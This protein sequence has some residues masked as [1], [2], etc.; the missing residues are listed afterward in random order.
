MVPSNI[1]ST[2][3]AYTA[4]ESTDRPLQRPLLMATTTSVGHNATITA[5]LTV[6]AD[7]VYDSDQTAHPTTTTNA[8]LP[9]LAPTEQAWMPTIPPNLTSI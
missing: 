8:A 1:Y 4:A 2:A 5:H 7:M 9:N 3:P 6:T